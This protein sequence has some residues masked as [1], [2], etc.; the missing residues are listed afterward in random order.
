MVFDLVTTKNLQTLIF[1]TSGGFA[2]LQDTLEIPVNK[3]TH[4][5]HRFP[6]FRTQVIGGRKTQSQ[7]GLSAADI[8]GLIR[9][10]NAANLANLNGKSFE[11]KQL[12]DGFNEVL[13]VTLSNGRSFKVSN[14]GDTAPPEYYAITQ[15][16]NKLKTEK[17]DKPAQ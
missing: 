10:I 15:Y 4:S 7:G 5:S 3:A 12:R 14:Y 11:Q 6:I 16:L 9:L 1:E 13:T 2:G 17:F 8:E